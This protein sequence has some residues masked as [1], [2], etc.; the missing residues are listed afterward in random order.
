MKNARFLGLLA[1]CL[2]VCG[3]NPGAPERAPVTSP[4][5]LL[6]QNGERRATTTLGDCPVSLE[7]RPADPYTIRYR[8][9]C[10]QIL[11][12]KAVLLGQLAEKLFGADGVPPEITSLGV[13]RLSSTFPEIAIRVALQIHDDDLDDFR[14]ARE[15]QQLNRFY[16]RY[17][18]DE[19]NFPEL[20]EVLARYGLRI[21]GASVE[22]VLA[23]TPSQTPFP[24]SLLSKG[25]P[26]DVVVPFDAQTWYKLEH[27][28]PAEI[29]E[30]ENEEE[31]A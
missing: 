20:Q 7:F 25:V 23:G 19:E 11:A 9:D 13:G 4:I 3:C 22:K 6:D 29:E 18:G 14:E 5:Q 10:S 26:A 27:Q 16:A 8:N 17:A 2:G 21:A 28:A 31:D 30:D 1:A 24:G 12:D 15:R